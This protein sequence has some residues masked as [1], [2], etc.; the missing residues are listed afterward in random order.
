[1]ASPAAGLQKALR[2]LLPEARN[3]LATGAAQGYVPYQR[4]LPRPSG[5][6]LI[7]ESR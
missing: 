7:S 2:L 5:E 6:M 3:R 1:M 4:D